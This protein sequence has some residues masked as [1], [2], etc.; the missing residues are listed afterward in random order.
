MSAAVLEGELPR[1][2]KHIIISVYSSGTH[3]RWWAGQA[4]S[5]ALFRALVCKVRRLPEGSRRDTGEGAGVSVTGGVGWMNSRH[6]PVQ[7][8]SRT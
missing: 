1:G 4:S 7:I 2:G 8:W 6:I 3:T 5:L